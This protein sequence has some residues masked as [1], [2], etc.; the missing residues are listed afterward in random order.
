MNIVIANRDV[1]D[2]A[3]T[4][5]IAPVELELVAGEEPPQAG[6]P[7]FSEV[8]AKAAA[9]GADALSKEEGRKKR[10]EAQILAEEQFRIAADRVKQA[11]GYSIGFET[12]WAYQPK[13]KPAYG[14]WKRVVPMLIQR[15][16]VLDMGVTA[17]AK[18]LDASEP[19][20][21]VT[22]DMMYDKLSPLAEKD[23]ARLLAKLGVTLMLRR[24]V[25]IRS[26]QRQLI[27][28][29]DAAKDLEVEEFSG[30]FVIRGDKAYVNG[31]PYKIQVG[32][33]GQRRIKIR[34]R[35][36]LPLDTLK[37][38]CLATE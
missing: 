29:R 9:D 24:P 26:V 20:Y 38:F 19:N 21:P 32:E 3:E 22:R 12:P 15:P 7:D 33:S 18:M 25:T 1:D 37:T 8:I 36:W 6:S 28:R 16:D 11:T 5:E 35:S 13:P 17:M 31:K 34:G 2:P 23:L 27:E 4:R 10:R 14:L 30:H